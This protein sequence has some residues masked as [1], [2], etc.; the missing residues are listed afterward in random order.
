M[1]VF[2]VFAVLFGSV[3]WVHHPVASLGLGGVYPTVRF[4]KVQCAVRSMHG[5]LRDEPKRS[6]AFLRCSLSAVTLTLSC[7][8]Q[9]VPFLVLHLE[10]WGLHYPTLL[11][12]SQNVPTSRTKTYKDRG[13]EMHWEF[14]P[15]LGITAPLIKEEGSL[16]QSFPYTTAASWQGLPGGWGAR[17]RR[18]EGKKKIG[19][20]PPC[21]SSDY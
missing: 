18:K 6:W 10:S 1:S 20:S 8:L 16:P 19:Y 14:A 15:C 21:P 11:H 13:G 12:S 3:L 17:E 5:Q 9:F 7:S 4:S 2:Q